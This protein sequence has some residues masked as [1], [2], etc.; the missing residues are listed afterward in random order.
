MFPD[1][2]PIYGGR[3]SAI[4]ILPFGAEAIMPKLTRDEFELVQI[5]GE[6]NSTGKSQ[7]QQWVKERNNLMSN[8]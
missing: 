7:W 6:P 8:L 1:I 2:P 4:L 3:V 5:D